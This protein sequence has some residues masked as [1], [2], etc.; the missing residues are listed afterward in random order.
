MTY[1]KTTTI[2][3]HSEK[4]KKNL[5]T[6]LDELKIEIEDTVNAIDGIEKIKKTTKDMLIVEED[7]PFLGGLEVIDII[8]NELNLDI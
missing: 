2:I 5:C 7:M 6:H 3:V 8:R 1:I 4:L